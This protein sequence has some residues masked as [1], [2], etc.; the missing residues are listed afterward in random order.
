[1]SDLKEQRTLKELLEQLDSLKTSLRG[2]DKEETCT[3]IQMIIGAAERERK[4]E[5][6]E[7]VHGMET[8]QKEK[9]ELAGEVRELQTRKE[10]LE[11]EREEYLRQKSDMQEKYEELAEKLGKISENAIARE[12]ELSGYHLRDQELKDREAALNRLEEQKKAEIEQLKEQFLKDAEAEKNLLMEKVLQKK[13]EIIS[14]AYAEK[15]KITAQ[16]AAR[17]EDLERKV[18]TLKE[19]ISYFRQLVMPI[20]REDPAE[21][22]GKD[23]DQAQNLREA[24]ERIGI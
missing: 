18:K 13:E 14:E 10:E 23:W 19:Q 20:L 21:E 3:Y 12:E 1:M 7:L 9:D 4:K 22:A 24:Y 2:Y 5:T 16:A 6:A 8:L 17:A 15:Q 11:K